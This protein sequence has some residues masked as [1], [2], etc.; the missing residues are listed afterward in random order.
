MKQSRTLLLLAFLIGLF[1]LEGFSLDIWQKYSKLSQLS[2]HFSQEK[3]LKGLGVKLKSQGTMQFKK[4][5]FFEWKVSSP[6][7]LA[8][9]FRGDSIELLENNKVVKSV[10]S[11]KFDPKMLNAITHLKAWLT[12]DQKFIEANYSITQLAKNLYEF[13]PIGTNKIFKS[14][15]IETGEKYPIKKIHMVELSDDS[16]EIEFSQTKLSYEN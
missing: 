12:I 16:I 15:K 2:T 5:D 13:T 10:D 7:A 14:I 8:F 9:I 4:P 11:T 1:P 6:K 3:E